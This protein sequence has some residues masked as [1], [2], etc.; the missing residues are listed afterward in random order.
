MIRQMKNL[1]ASTGN[2]QADYKYVIRKSSDL[3]VPNMVLVE[4]A[5]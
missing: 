2:S 4:M 5:I 1:K 3:G